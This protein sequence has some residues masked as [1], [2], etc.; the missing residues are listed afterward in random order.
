MNQD[1]TKLQPIQVTCRLDPELA[2]QLI[3]L[4]R[5]ERRSV[6]AQLVIIVEEFFA[7]SEG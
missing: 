5:R 2:E 3:E 7:K 1:T 6:S 4:A